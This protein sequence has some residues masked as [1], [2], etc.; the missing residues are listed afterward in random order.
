MKNKF[1]IAFNNLLAANELAYFN[2]QTPL[3]DAE[4]AG[5]LIRMVPESR[6]AQRMILPRTDPDHLSFNEARTH[7]NAYRPGK[8]A[9]PRCVSFRYNLNGV[10][11][12]GKAHNEEGVLT[13]ERQ[14]VIFSRLMQRNFGSDKPLDATRMIHVVTEK[15]PPI[16]G[17][18]QSVLSGTS[19][20]DQGA[21][22]RS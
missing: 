13:R 22:Q 5:L 7:H 20:L 14:G 6:M 9:K 8:D 21:L 17:H 4:L 16:L 3:R 10:R 11:M 2:G 12:P 1:G 19:G 15:A 18:L